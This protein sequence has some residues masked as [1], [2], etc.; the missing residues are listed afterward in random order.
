[1][2]EYQEELKT[3][4]RSAR[5][6]LDEIEACEVKPQSRPIIGKCFRHQSVYASPH[7]DARYWPLYLMISGGEDRYLYGIRFEKD[8]SG[9]IAITPDCEMPSTWSEDYEQVSRPEFIAE[10]R[11]LLETKGFENSQ[12]RGVA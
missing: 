11:K 1:M 2:K 5:H 10:W 7:S 12:Y 4:I 3:I 9:K 8:S 6:K